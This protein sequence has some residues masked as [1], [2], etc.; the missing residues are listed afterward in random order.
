MEARGK[1]S[2]GFLAVDCEG[3]TLLEKKAIP[4]HEFITKRKSLPL[5]VRSVLLHTR[6]ATQGDPS[7]NANNHPVQHGTIFTTH[8]GHIRNDDEVF[9]ELGIKRNAQVDSEAIPAA[10]YKKEFDP[11][12]FELLDGGFATASVDV[13]QP[14][15]VMLAKGPSYPLIVHE[16][17]KFIVWASTKNTITDAWKAALG[18]DAPDD[19]TFRWLGDG[20]VM[21]LDK[22]AVTLT[23]NAFQSKRYYTSGYSSWRG[24]DD[25][26]DPTYYFDDKNGRINRSSR[27]PRGRSVT[28]T[29]A[30]REDVCALRAKGEGNAVTWEDRQ[31]M[32]AFKKQLH[33]GRW[34]FCNACKTTVIEIDAI[35]SKTYGLV[36]IDCYAWAVAK[37][38]ADNGETKLLTADE[39]RDVE[40]WVKVEA[41]IHIAAIVDTADEFGFTPDSVEY[42]LFR[43]SAAYLNNNPR[44]KTIHDA[45]LKFYEEAMANAW[46]EYLEEWDQAEQDAEDALDMSPCVVCGVNSDEREVNC[47]SCQFRKD[48]KSVKDMTYERKDK[49]ASLLKTR[50]CLTC[51]K[52][53]KIYMGLKHQWCAKH[54]EKCKGNRS[55]K[56]T[57]VATGADGHRYCHV[58]NR[59]NKGSIQ[60]GDRYRSP[61]A[62][63]R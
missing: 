28:T 50:T 8:N 11:K 57:T 34:H 18:D 51:G 44:Q 15:M 39:I 6:L 13:R 27:Q 9:D 59:G 5:G 26:D 3:G 35:D 2:T 31:S 16:N 54:Y 30:S 17:K 47:P 46:D 52:P 12:A 42:I 38:H 48:G 29:P 24:W 40:E 55:C 43:M 53:A 19:N 10:L 22:D 20:D 56:G 1:D 36:C 4:A 61:L 23:K 63:R 62:T 58:H 49:N 45:V 32:P 60:D 37:D 25:D 41:P 14:G 33:N 21:L 7:N